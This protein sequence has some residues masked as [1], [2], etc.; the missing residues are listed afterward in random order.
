M[1]IRALQDYTFYAKYAKYNSAKKR[2]E[3]WVETVDRVFA[4][5]E[6]K[7]EKVLKENE[8]FRTEFYFAKEQ[9][10][11]K[12]FLGAQRALQFGGDPILQ[13]KSGAFVTLKKDGELRGCIG[14]F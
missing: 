3:T 1:S 4:M 8:E 2:R 14:R 10:L 7:F 9:V 11:K 12:R 6:K 13:K 5:H